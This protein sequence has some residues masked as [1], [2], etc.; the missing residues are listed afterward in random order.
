[1]FG[2]IN[3]NRAY[4]KIWQRGLKTCRATGMRRRFGYK[5]L[6]GHWER[7]RFMNLQLAGKWIANTRMPALIENA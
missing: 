6:F 2:V 5:S 1:M 7:L 4:K 3:S